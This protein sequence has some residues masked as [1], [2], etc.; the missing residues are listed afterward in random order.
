MNPLFGAIREVD[1]WKTSSI[2]GKLRI[3]RSDHK[4]LLCKNCCWC[5]K[6]EEN[7]V[8]LNSSVH[9]IVTRLPD[10]YTDH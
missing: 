8:K 9:R 10:T 5:E 3:K 6:I 7:W 4:L 2:R 1:F